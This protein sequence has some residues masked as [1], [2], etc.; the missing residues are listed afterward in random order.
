MDC[1][2][3]P[4]N[5]PI[6]YHGRTL[7]TK[8]KFSDVIKAIKE[9]AFITSDYPVILSVEQHC[10]IGQQGVMARLFKEVF[11]GRNEMR[12][13]GR[14]REREGGAGERGEKERGGAG[15]ERGGK[16]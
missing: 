14:E 11:G 7:T 3:G 10:D 9:H 1:W 16:K 4:D 8:I 15:R 5:E 6:I 12:E 2:D 13:G